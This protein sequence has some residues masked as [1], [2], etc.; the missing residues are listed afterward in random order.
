MKYFLI[1]Y[2]A[3]HLSTKGK[4]IAKVETYE[5]LVMAEN[6]DAAIEKL[7]RL[8]NDFDL[9]ENKTIE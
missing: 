2:K 4:W 7:K 9:I 5:H 8:Y 6:F 1:K 3:T